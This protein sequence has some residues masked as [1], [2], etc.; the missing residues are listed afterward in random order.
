[1]NLLF[2]L[3]HNTQ[4]GGLGLG[5]SG[6]NNTSNANIEAVKEEFMTRINL[7]LNIIL[8]LYL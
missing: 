3:G 2:D 8:R 1:M 7:Q 5:N 6:S 4:Q